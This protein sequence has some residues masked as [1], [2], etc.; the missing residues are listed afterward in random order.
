MIFG[1]LSISGSFERTTS[2]MSCLHLRSFFSHIEWYGISD[3]T[4]QHPYGVDG[5]PEAGK[6]KEFTGNCKT[7][8]KGLNEKK[9]GEKKKGNMIQSGHRKIKQTKVSQQNPRT[10]EANKTRP[11]TQKRIK[12]ARHR[13]KKNDR[14]KISK[15]VHMYPPRKNN[16]PAR[17]PPAVE[18]CS[19]P[20]R[21]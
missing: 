16:S 21:A 5:Q 18:G 11:R 14:K 19:S 20:G 17:C 7:K 15:K 10:V 8:K 13:E 2:R 1:T 6:Q 12:N 9:A 3:R 4:G